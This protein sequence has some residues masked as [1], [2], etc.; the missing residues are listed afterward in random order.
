MAKSPSVVV[1]GAPQEEANIISKQLSGLIEVVSVVRDPEQ[2][3]ELVRQK[4]PNIALLYLDESP[5]EIL[6]ATA[7]IAQINGCSPVVVSRDRDPDNILQAM[8]SGAKDYAYLEDDGL[9]VRRVLLSLSL[10]PVPEQ[11]AARRGMVVAVFAAK[12]GCGATTIAANLSGALM[13]EGIEKAERKGQVALLDLDLQMGDVL[14]FL[15]LS[16]RYTWRD[17][18][19]NLHRLDDELLHQSLTMHPLGLNIVA[20]SDVLEEAEDIDPKSIGKAISFLRRH[21]E[22]VVIDGLRNF[23]ELSLVALDLADRVL[24][25]M[26]QDIPALKNANRCLSIFRQLGYDRNKVKLVLNR[27]LKRGD[28][29]TDAIAD[30][31]GM[32]VEGTVANDFPTVIKAINEGSL[33]VNVAPR[34]KVT[35]DIRALVPMIRGE[36]PARKGLFGRRRA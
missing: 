12:G 31:L 29:D 32:P 26:T 28:L 11:Q 15:D 18:V 1:I 10:S 2:G 33:L 35:K 16:S 5:G 8:R 22:Y 36:P 14:A 30:A 7:R 27:Y 13:P 23:S 3:L 6:K 19:T 25:T 9:D 21:F 24:L 34:A 20:Q 4:T 17:L